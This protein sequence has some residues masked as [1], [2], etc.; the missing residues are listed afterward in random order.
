[1]TMTNR[2]NQKRDSFILYTL[3][4]LVPQDHLVRKIE[5]C[6]DF[7]FIYPKVEGLYSSIGRPSIDPVVLLKCYLSISSS[8]SILCERHVKK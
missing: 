1:M 4:E 5:S 6:I 3:E 7:S 8:A 2:H